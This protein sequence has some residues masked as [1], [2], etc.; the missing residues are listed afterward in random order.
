MNE[1]AVLSA[2][3]L[4]AE[5]LP[6]ARVEHADHHRADIHEELP[7]EPGPRCCIHEPGHAVLVRGPSKRDRIRYRKS[8]MSTLTLEDI[9]P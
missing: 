8:M 4:V 6:V 2:W 5:A 9:L 3:N 1:G 7:G